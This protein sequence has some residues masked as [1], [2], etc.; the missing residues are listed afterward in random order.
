MSQPE[1][2]Y[3]L[4]KFFFMRDY[5]SL[6]LRCQ[7]IPYYSRWMLTLLGWN[8]ILQSLHV[9]TKDVDLR[10]D[11]LYAISSL[12]SGREKTCE[13]TREHTSRQTPQSSSVH[14]LPK[15]F[16]KSAGYSSWNLCS[17]SNMP[18]FQEPPIENEEILY[19]YE[20]IDDVWYSL[21]DKS[22]RSV[23]QEI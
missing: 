13:G 21:P 15:V 23:C 8:L 5:L 10:F 7:R 12:N 2:G 18:E 6:C 9:S 22:R 4:V 14:Y 17:R 16:N 20:K 1:Y 11:V 19:P 3:A